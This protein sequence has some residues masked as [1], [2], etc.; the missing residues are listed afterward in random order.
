MFIC[1]RCSYLKALV[2]DHFSEASLSD[3]SEVQVITLHDIDPHA[4]VTMLQYI[5]TDSAEVN[6]VI[7]K[8]ISASSV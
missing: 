2:T 7:I 1:G 4:F 3:G 6:L 8:K 5:Y